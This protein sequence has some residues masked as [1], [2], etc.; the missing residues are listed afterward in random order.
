MSDQA[1][2]TLEDAERAYHISRWGDGYFWINEKGNLA[3]LP[4][5]DPSGPRI[6]I[7]E[8]IEE[9]T[10]EQ[11]TL[12][13][14]IRFHDILRSQVKVLNR[15]FRE[16]I[17][18]SNY[19]GRFMGVYPIKVNQMREVVEEIVDAGAPFHF[20]LEAGSKPE[21]LSVLAL[22]TNKHSLTVL[23]GYKD[24]DYLKLALLGLK[25]GRNMIVV[26]EKFSELT[27]LLKLADEMKVK[28][29]V[30][31]RCRMSVKGRGKWA[32]SSGERAKFGLTT[33]ELINAVN[34]LKE[35]GLLDCLKLFHFHIGSQITD[36]RTVKD[37]ITEAAR[38]Y[39]KLIKM[40]ADI[41]YMDVGG[42][43]GVDYDGSRSTNESSMNYTLNAY[44]EDIVYGLKQICDLEEVPHPNI[45][46][47]SGRFI[48]AHHS[49]VIM[50]VV[51]R[52]DTSFT[53][54]E[55]KRVTDEHHLV[56][57]MRELS[58]DINEDN[59][60]TVA[61]EA[62]QIKEDVINAFRLGVMTLE[63]RAKVETLYWQIQHKIVDKIKGGEFV[64]EGLYNLEDD[65]APQYLCNFSIFQSAADSWAIDQ[66]LPVAPISKLNERPEQMC[67]SGRYYL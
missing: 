30:G 9:M 31:L 18:E 41:R 33:P 49:C 35:R 39:A 7:S 17:E 63:E 34:L 2:W 55:T 21:L 62:Q 20:G 43:L 60:Q 28:P 54:F 64:P 4:N 59:L 15:T 11:I 26:V 58:L 44:C 23:N 40:G 13:A 38:I 61:S 51:D 12:P 66:L 48:T 6:D 36:I 46:T 47:E 57:N 22:N 42:G 27:S 29:V 10:K 37:A 32:G 14:V 3:V 1:D 67:S 25:M 24:D 16:V 52:I 19:E 5:R 56:N 45:I 8:V 50:K 65:L 53:H